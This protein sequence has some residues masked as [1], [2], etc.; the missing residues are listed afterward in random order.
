MVGAA[1]RGEPTDL[2]GPH[3]SEAA[4]LTDSEAMA[5]TASESESRLRR[6][7]CACW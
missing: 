2:A 1:A 3:L 6:R 5:L 7:L 4:A